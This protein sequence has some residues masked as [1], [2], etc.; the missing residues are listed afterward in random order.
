MMPGLHVMRF[1]LE[2]AQAASDEWGFNCGPGALCA[3]LGKT[4]RLAAG[5]DRTEGQW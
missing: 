1:G 2:E 5:K 4:P 3:V